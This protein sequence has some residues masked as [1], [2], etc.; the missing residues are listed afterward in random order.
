MNMFNKV[1]L[2]KPAR[3]KFDLTHV[4]ALTG[5]MGN[6]IP[7][8]WQEILPGDKMSNVSDVMV[9]FTPMLAPMFAHCDV[10]LDYFYVADRT[11]WNESEK[12]HTGGEDGTDAPVAP[13]ITIA[14][15]NKSITG[16]S[17]LLDYYGMPDLSAQAFGA[18]T[19]KIS[20]LFLRAGLKV[21]NEYYRN[22]N[23]LAPIQTS[24]GSG[25]ES[26][27]DTTEL[28]TLRKTMWE[29]DRFTSALVDTQRGPQ[30]L[31]PMEGVG[32]GA[33]IT[34]K[35]ISLVKDA[36][37]G[38][39]PATVPD[40][41]LVDGGSSAAGNLQYD[42]GTTQLSARLENIDS[43]TVDNVSI[44][45]IDL[46]RAEKLQKFLE[47]SNV[48]GGRYK[49]YLEAHWHVYS[50]DG[51]LQRAEYLGGSRQKVVISEVLSTATEDGN[52]DIP[53]QGNMAGHG[54][55]MGRSNKWTRKFEEHGHVIGFLRVL[56]RTQYFTGIPKSMQRFDRFDY[57]VPDMDQIGEQPV[58]TREIYAKVND[59]AYDAVFGY[60]DQYSEYKYAPST[61]HGQMKDAYLPW[62]MARQLTA[63]PI[64]NLSFVEADPTTR[65]FAVPDVE[66]L[67]M[68]ITNH[69]HVVRSLHYFGT[70]TL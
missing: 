13:Y 14:E 53:P 39:R 35:T 65:N 50:S 45:I 42:N 29:K 61:I 17:T 40:H 15:A 30:V 54:I 24:L 25:A 63:P 67:I 66:N 69:C 20:S 22:Q 56:P 10:K 60:Q 21:Y 23:V 1:Q 7:V 3:S 5:W 57:A 41:L 12:F 68:K 27:P 49:E 19:V 18:A 58:M 28:T 11:I 32:S 31:I 46:R 26:A 64:L 51:R 70:G 36:T 52:P 44:T 4:K 48:A 9:R 38:L 34:Y 6:L 55:S 33:D 2:N 47:K 43:I 37:S 62:N 59:P 8:F 16:I